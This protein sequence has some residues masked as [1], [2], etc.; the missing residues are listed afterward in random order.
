MGMTVSGVAP[1]PAQI[2]KVCGRFVTG[3]AIVTSAGSE[4]AVGVTINSFS[5]VSLEP[6][7]VL[8]CVHS[9]SRIRMALSESRAFAVN[10][11]AED[12][13]SIC[14]SFSSRDSSDFSGVRRHVGETGAPIISDSL[15]YLECRSKKNTWP[16]TT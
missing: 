16:A 1:D 9:R 13:V 14:R 7:M 8:F 15:A 11:L 12:Q 6:P 2:R 3:V 5:S 10:I 4:G